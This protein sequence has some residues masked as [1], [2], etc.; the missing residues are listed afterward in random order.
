MK[1]AVK[2]IDFLIQAVVLATVLFFLLLF[3]TEGYFYWG[4]VALALYGILSSVIHL[5]LRFPIA[6]FRIIVWVA[7]GILLLLLAGF[8]MAGHPFS[9]LNAIIYPGAF[10]IAFLYLILTISDLQESKQGGKDYLDF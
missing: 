2:L 8:W 3:S 5:A 9:Q 7:Y 1:Y 4:I 6:T 10:L